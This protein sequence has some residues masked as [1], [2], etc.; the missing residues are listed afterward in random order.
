MR[1][2]VNCGEI[3]RADRDDRGLNLV[4]S[5]LVNAIISDHSCHPGECSLLLRSREGVSRGLAIDFE[6]IR[7]GRV[8]ACCAVGLFAKK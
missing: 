7:P 6:P 5:N 3:A 2:A 1:P 8:L 4:E